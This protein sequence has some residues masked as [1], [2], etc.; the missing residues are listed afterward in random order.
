MTVV[1]FKRCHRDGQKE[2][3]TISADAA[4][5]FP[6]YEPSELPFLYSALLSSNHFVS[7]Q[8]QFSC[9]NCNPKANHGNN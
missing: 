4:R 7:S 9:L 2:Y 5:L 3:Y 8:N 6:G 1:F